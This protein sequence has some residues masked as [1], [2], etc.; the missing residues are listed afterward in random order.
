M[1]S[2]RERGRGGLRGAHAPFFRIWLAAH[3]LPE[4]MS[5]TSPPPPAAEHIV[6]LSS[7]VLN[8]QPAPP[9]ETAPSVF[10]DDTTAQVHAACRAPADALAACKK[11]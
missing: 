3:F 2:G 7:D 4:R 1:L 10:Y 8:F 6:V 9:G 5:A 11:T